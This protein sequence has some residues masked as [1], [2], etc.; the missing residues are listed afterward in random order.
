MHSA[1]VS[2]SSDVLADNPLSSG[3]FDRYVS[4][5]GYS[6]Y[7]FSVSRQSSEFIKNSEIYTKPKTSGIYTILVPLTFDGV[8]C[9]SVEYV[10]ENRMDANNA[11]PIIKKYKI[12][13]TAITKPSELVNGQNI[14]FD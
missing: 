1:K 2:I 5:V 13:G 14:L 3:A 4:F 8:A 6:Y 9:K 11:Y 7:N 12:E 10:T